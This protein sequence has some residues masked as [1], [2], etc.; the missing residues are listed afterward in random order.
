MALQTDRTSSPGPGLEFEE[1]Q[2]H[3]GASVVSENVPHVQSAAVG[4]WIRYGSRDESAG[5]SGMAHFIEH[6]VFKG[7]GGRS[8]HSIASR[9]E[10]VGGYLNAF[11][12][13]DL[14]CYYARVPGRALATAVEQLAALVRAPHFAEAEITREKRVVV[15]EMRS[16]EDDPEDIIY[17]HL[18]ACLFGH[19]PLGR[20]IIGAE[21]SIGRLTRES[22]LNC[23]QKHYIGRNMVIAASGAV[24]H[25]S[26]VRM[27]SR[28]FG[29]LPP[30]RRQVRRIPVIRPREE[31]SL[32]HSHQQSHL[33]FGRCVPGQ[34]HLDSDV[35]MLLNLIL[36]DSM[37]SRLFQRIRERHGCAYNIYSS[38]ALY[39]DTGV[40]S[41]YLA[42]DAKHMPGCRERVVR[43]LDLIRTG[44]VTVREL[45]RAK[46]QAV[47]S[48][49][50]GLESMST[51]MNRLGKDRLLL[52]R[53]VPVP[54]IVKT[55]TDITVEDISRVA[56]YA[57]DAGS[58]T[59]IQMNPGYQAD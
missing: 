26:L 16:I 25:D 42:S 55:I 30:G 8:A 51:R 21:E 22:L 47:G 15:D 9:I 38:L 50:M 34:S 46:T 41:I 4:V 2:L 31:K 59:E 14:T 56:A 54:E 28:S 58:M 52:G 7:A 40:L 35:L 39:E 11:T 48:L 33:V 19:H 53:V 5:Q 45:D 32:P 24:D 57:C 1:T 49:L 17:D 6:A 13:K 29:E 10:S 36:G 20:P 27:C 23:V 37:S 12:S 18:E 44:G 43:E 3:S